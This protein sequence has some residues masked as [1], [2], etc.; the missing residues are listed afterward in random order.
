MTDE[1]KGIGAVYH[2]VSK[3]YLQSYLDEYSYRY[4]RRDQGNLIFISLL[5]RVSQRADLLP[6]ARDRGMNLA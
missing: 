4:N 1:K 2:S 6:A 5:K 3:K